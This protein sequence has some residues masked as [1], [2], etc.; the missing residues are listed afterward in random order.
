M[1]NTNENVVCFDVDETIVHWHSSDDPTTDMWV[2]VQDKD[3]H[4]EKRVRINTKT[5]DKIKGHAQVGHFVIVWSAGGYAW[6]NAVINEL[7]LNSFVNMVS[8]KPKW[9]VDDEPADV[10]MR[11][12]I[13]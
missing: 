7:G 11:R 12:I 4:I 1:L 2:I 5:V 6:A 8:T 3:K 9:Y 10:F 13:P